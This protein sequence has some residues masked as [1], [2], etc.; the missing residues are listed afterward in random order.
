MSS[1]NEMNF[2]LI[3]KLVSN[4]QSNCCNSKE[5]LIVIIS[6]DQTDKQCSTMAICPSCNTKYSIGEDAQL[7]VSQSK[8]SKIVCD[9]KTHSCSVV[10]DPT[11]KAG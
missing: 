10:V 1:I 8:G 4:G 5:K 11:E 2:N 9:S 7:I 6:C 3:E